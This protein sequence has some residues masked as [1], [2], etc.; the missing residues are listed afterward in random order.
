MACP[1]SIRLSAE[2]PDSQGSNQTFYA[3]E[4]TAAHALAEL[5]LKRNVE[6]DT[7]VGIELEGFVVDE[8]MAAYVKVFTDYVRGTPHAPRWVEKQFNLAALNP[9]APMFGTAD[10]V[11]YDAPARILE[12][13]DLKYGQGVV[14]NVN[15]NPQL[16]YY[17]LGALLSMDLKHF[18]VEKVKITI[19]QP[20]ALHPNGPIRSEEISVEELVE[21]AGELLEA[22][23][24]TLKPDAPLHAG[25]HCRF[26]P[27]SGRCPEQRNRAQLV[28]QSDFA[29]TDFKPPAPGLLTPQQF[30][31]MLGQLHILDDWMKA[32]RAHAQAM[33]ER[34]EE[35]PGFK[36]VQ[37]RA[38]RKWADEDAA[39]A[40][41][42]AKGNVHEEIFEMDLKSPAQ[43]EKL[44]GKKN[45]PPE[46]VVKV[47]SGTS[48]VPDS[49]PRPEVVMSLG[50]E[51]PA[52]PSGD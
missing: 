15:G 32:M 48:M 10:F 51:F 13:V 26:C 3:A 28:A 36:L 25:S 40:W 42:E 47:S 46:L 44:V 7:F 37:K 52:L 5:A 18:P 38:T 41:L 21:F 1:G 31:T 2:V 35:V 16:R 20:R 39:I 29:V 49:D 17:G 4:G 33:L 24:A 11:G 22:A 6:P 27:A 14:V 9:P 12:V 45:L 19:V 23:R 34:G 8:D 30:S 43:I 50:Q